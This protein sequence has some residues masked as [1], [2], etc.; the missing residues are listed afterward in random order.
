MLYQL[1]ELQH[2]AITPW[3]QIN[4]IMRRT[5]K[6]PWNPVSY[7][8]AGRMA[9]A[10]C[11][12][13]ERLTRRYG[14]PDF[15][16]DSI[17]VQGR[18]IEIAELEVLARPFCTLKR[19]RRRGPEQDVTPL[20]R[21]LIVA[22]LSGHYATLLRGTVRALLAD[23][24]VFITDWH[25]ARDVPVNAGEFT[26]DD[27]IAYVIDFLRFL[28]PCTHVLAV[29][30]PGPAVLSATALMAEDGDPCRPLSMTLMGSPIDTSRSPTVPNQLAVKRP[31]QWF[32]RHLIMQVPFPQRGF[33]RWVYPGFLQLS[34]FMQMNSDTHLDKHTAF[35]YD[36]IK[37]D[38]ESAEAHR[39][40]YDEY[41]AVMDM[42]AEYYLDTIDKVFQQRLLPRGLMTWRGRKVE[43]G[44]ITDT[45]LMTVEGENDDISGVGQTQAAHDLC[46][47]IPA[48][49]HEDYVQPGVGHYG[50][51]NGSR[52]RTEIAP[53]V[54]R[55]I[56]RHDLPRSRGTARPKLRGIAGGQG[57]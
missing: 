27:Y 38:G 15:G 56:A 41:L 39:R 55:F 16:I 26:L 24:E 4:R 11:E 25:D 50:V 32:R 34:G 54:A 23:H 35:F 12:V 3:R 49:M 44:A 1:Y 21:L 57:G 52:W 14:K 9:A 2:A 6:A 42:P 18:T 20:P 48:S 53:R 36:L 28:G 43:P 19:F 13:F 51:F 30:Q 33:T 45:A 37:G 5:L 17:E 46:T 47:S 8:A 10:S 31:L 40:F 7:T 29:C 22:P